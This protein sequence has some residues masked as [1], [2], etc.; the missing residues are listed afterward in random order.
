MLTEQHY[1]RMLCMNTACWAQVSNHICPWCWSNRIEN[2]GTQ[3]QITKKGG[4]TITERLGWNPE[5]LQIPSL[6]SHCLETMKPDSCNRSLISGDF[7]QRTQLDQNR[8]FLTRPLCS[9]L[10]APSML[11]PLQRS[12][13]MPQT[14]SLAMWHSEQSHRLVFSSHYTPTSWVYRRMCVSTH[15]CIG[16]LWTCG[17]LFNLAFF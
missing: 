15:V 1:C 4:P 11:L 5:G 2:G 13:S 7:A 8:P 9:F 14:G 16:P 12:F 3:G 6:K 10:A 17:T